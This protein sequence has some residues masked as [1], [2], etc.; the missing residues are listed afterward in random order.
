MQISN[1]LKYPENILYCGIMIEE[2]HRNITCGG[3]PFN[4]IKSVI[5]GLYFQLDPGQDAK[6]MVLREKFPYERNVFESL[7]KNSK[8]KVVS[9]EEKDKE[10]HIV[11]R[12]DF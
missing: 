8:L 5:K 6:I 11:V 3:D 1:T 9:F 10:L 2:D 7:A 12:R 4:Y